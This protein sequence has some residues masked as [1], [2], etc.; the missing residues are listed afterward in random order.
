MAIKLEMGSQRFQNGLSE[1]P[2]AKQLTQR[3]RRQK[4]PAELQLRQKLSKLHSR[5]SIKQ[6]ELQPLQLQG[7]LGQKE[8][9]TKKQVF[10]E[11]EMS[12]DE[13]HRTAAAQAAIQPQQEVWFRKSP[14]TPVSERTELLCEPPVR[15]APPR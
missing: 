5:F 13:R 4:P 11:A 14:F 10:N 12:A 6:A 8:A 3:N 7:E 15:H 9:E 2:R 1:P